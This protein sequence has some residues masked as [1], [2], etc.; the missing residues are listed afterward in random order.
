MTSS[1]RKGNY[2][3]NLDSIKDNR[4]KMQYFVEVVDNTTNKV[5]EQKEFN[6]PLQQMSFVRNYIGVKKYEK[7]KERKNVPDFMWYPNTIYTKPSLSFE[8]KM[9]IKPKD[10]HVNIFKPIEI[11]I[12]Y[13]D[14]TNK[15][16]DDSGYEN[17]LHYNYAKEQKKAGNI[18][19]FQ[20]ELEYR[21]KKIEHI[22]KY[23]EE[24]GFVGQLGMGM[25]T[26]SRIA[27]EMKSHIKEI[28][29]SLKSVKPQEPIIQHKKKPVVVKK[30]IPKRQTI[31]D[32]FGFKGILGTSAPKPK[33]KPK[34]K[35]KPIVKKIEMKSKKKEIKKK[36][37]VSPVKVKSYFRFA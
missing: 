13:V 33:P 28:K 10:K 31:S 34:Q 5:I 19:P 35:P 32:P 12:K 24:P 29:Q 16:K 8:T 14:V 15:P 25:K 20:E 18:E 36:K 9:F 6:T 7:E 3:L 26:H 23:G 4:G 11:P 17:V 21:L 37:C 27:S 22:K 2:T 1:I 30:V